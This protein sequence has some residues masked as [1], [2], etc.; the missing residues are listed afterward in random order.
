MFISRPEWVGRPAGYGPRVKRRT[1]AETRQLLLDVGIAMVYE[2]GVT[3]GVGHIRLRDVLDRA[4]LT[5]GAAYR[6]WPDQSAFQRDLAVAAATWR[7]DKPLGRTVA[8]IRELIADEAPL[9]AVI[10][11]GSATHIDDLVHGDGNEAWPSSSFLTALALRAAAAH[12]DPLR[13]ASAARHQES[14]SSFVALYEAMLSLYGRR[15][16]PPL[17]VEHLAVAMAALGEG[18]ALQA[19]EGEE[20]PM[21]SMPV[22]GADEDEEWTLFGVAVEA[23]V[24]SFTETDP[25]AA[26]PGG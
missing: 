20:H 3:A 6:L 15:M 4:K 21:L 24:E 16:R 22:D 14:V 9:R 1:A 25:E 13:A 26:R 5:T 12:S 19:I 8:A 10:R 7:A 18:F 23:I 11:R 2:Q 17:T